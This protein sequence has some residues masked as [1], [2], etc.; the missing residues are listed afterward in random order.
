MKK[1]LGF[2]LTLVLAIGACA[3]SMQP[4]A[5]WAGQLW[6]STFALYGTKG[7]T[8]HFLCT[9]E[10]IEK[11]V[12]GYRLLTAGHCVQETPAGLQFSVA[13]E[14]GGARTPITL[15]KVRLDETADFAVFDLQ[16]P[17]TYTV[18]PLGNESELQIGDST[19]NPNFALGIGKQLSP[20]VVSAMPLVPS[21]GCTIAD[22]CVGDFMVQEFAGPGASGS[23]VLSVKTHQVVG[24]IVWEFG[25]GNV[26]LGVEPISQFAAFMAGPTQAHPA[27]ETAT[28]A[29]SVQIP[30]NVFAA[31]FGPKHTFKLKVHGPNPAFT[32]GGYK[33]R[34]NTDGFELSDKYYYKAKVF[35][36]QDESG[37]YLV[38]TKDGVSV[39]V[40]VLGKE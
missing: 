6:G 12:G 7:T 37:Y 2:F 8:T 14:I 31:Q 34:A 29:E 32:Q 39:D 18:F 17:K 13:D 36:G 33:F 21:E 35:I 23:A 1:F 4:P 30:A 26:G 22:G 9:A 38:S 24:L 16:T 10:P 25:Q 5:G 40:A 19:I 27:D 28:A 11:I 3:G 20:G 15:V